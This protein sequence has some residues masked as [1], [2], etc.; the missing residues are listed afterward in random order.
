MKFEPI[1]A[2]NLLKLAA[3]YAAAKGL[4]TSTVGYYFASDDKVFAR[5]EA[6]GSF[7]VRAYDD[8]IAR[9]SVTWPPGLEWPNEI[10][11]PNPAEIDVEVVF[12]KGKR[13]PDHILN[14]AA[15]PKAEGE[16]PEN[17]EEHQG[18]SEDG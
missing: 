17:G 18:R 10:P 3:R 5:I 16:N 7:S 13:P 11:R 4:R 9:F 1:F 2:S 8:M 6:G 14:P 12:G 15:I